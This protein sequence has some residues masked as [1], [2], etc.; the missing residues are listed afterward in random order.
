[1]QKV[2]RRLEQL[3]K[4]AKRHLL[5]PPVVL[6]H[7]I[8]CERANDDPGRDRAWPAGL[9]TFP[10][11]RRVRLPGSGSPE[12]DLQAANLRI[13]TSAAGSRAARLPAGSMTSAHGPCD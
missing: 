6:T 3:E 8:S 13:T 4:I 5:L 12:P 10:P 1:M 2:R 7:R 9:P 11:Q